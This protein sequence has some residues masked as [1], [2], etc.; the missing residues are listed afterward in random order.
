[1]L[2]EGLDD[3]FLKWIF[4]FENE[5][6]YTW[7]PNKQCKQV[8]FAFK[9]FFFVVYQKS[10]LQHLTLC[11]N[12]YNCQKVI[13]C[14][15]IGTTLQPQNSLKLNFQPRIKASTGYQTKR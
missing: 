7:C 8:F 13:Q 9:K 2:R 4:S 12:I 11:S 14:R 6:K 3:N 15:N 1:M 5:N 10:F